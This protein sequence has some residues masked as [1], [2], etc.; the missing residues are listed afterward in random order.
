MRLGHR[1]FVALFLARRGCI[2][3]ASADETA[4]VYDASMTFKVKMGSQK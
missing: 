1:S 3:R 2:L 4:W